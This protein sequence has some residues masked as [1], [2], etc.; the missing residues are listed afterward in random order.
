MREN[1][2]R[3]LHRQLQWHYD[4]NTKKSSS[5]RHQRT[6]TPSTSATASIYSGDG[7]NTSCED[8]DT[9]T[10]GKQSSAASTAARYDDDDDDGDRV[11]ILSRGQSPAKSPS[12][13]SWASKSTNPFRKHMIQA[14]ESSDAGKSGSMSANIWDDPVAASTT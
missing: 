6:Y 9:D 11:S 14:K 7:N 13:A 10:E 2:Y 5:T 1:N 4:K 3:R 8:S 12:V